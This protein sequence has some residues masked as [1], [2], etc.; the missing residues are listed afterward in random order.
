MTARRLWTTIN[1]MSEEELRLQ[2]VIPVLRASPDVQS[3]TDVHGQ[4]ER[5]LDVI[6]FTETDIERICYGLQLKKGAISGG[7]TGGKTV[8]QIVDQLQLADDYSHPIATKN[9]G[10]V[11][12]DRF[13]VATSGRISGTA[14]TEIASR[15]KKIPVQF[16]D[17]NELIRRIHKYLPQL[18]QVS[19]AASVSYLRTIQHR[20]DVLDALDQ[21]PGVAKRTLTQVFEEPRL[22]RIFDPTIA[23]TEAGQA[24]SGTLKALSLLSVEH[25]S[26]LIAD[27]DAGKTS[28]LRM[29]ALQ[30]VRGILSGALTG[31]PLPV[32]IRARDILSK[33]LSVP[34]AIASEFRRLGERELAE[35][36]NEDLSIGNYYVAVDSFSELSA[37]EDKTR[38]ALMIEE[39]SRE[40]PL[41]RVI[42]AGRPA[43]F[44]TPRYF[45]DFFHY[46]IDDFD[47]NQ[48][49]SLVRRWIGDSPKWAD[50]AHKMVDRLRE[51]LQLP[52]SPIPATIGVMLHEEQGRYITNTAEAIDRYMV[53]RLGRY[54]HELGMKQEVDW[55]RKQ[56]LLSEVAY[57]MVE[58]GSELIAEAEF[59]AQIEDIQRRQ[60]DTPRGQ[61][62]LEELVGSG[63]LSREAGGLSFFRTSFRDFF[64]AH[65]V[66]QRGDL[67][68]F[69]VEN[70]FER[71]WAST[72]VFAA[73]LRRS[74][75]R[76]LNSISAAVERHRANSVGGRPSDDY[77]FAAWVCGRV[78]ANSESADHGPKVAALRTTLAAASASVPELT[79]QATEQYGN[80]GHLMAIV[81]AEHSFF[82]AVGVPWIRNQLLEILNDSAIADE[83][84]YFLASVYTNLGYDDCYSVLTRAISEATSTKVLVVLQLLLWQLDETRR[85]EGPE[86]VALNQLKRSV[87]RRLAKRTQEVKSL[88]QLKSPALRLEVER[89]RR[90]Q[91]E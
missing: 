47:T 23:A 38:V 45:L 13:I 28:I 89:M 35:T 41:V 32:L 54:A 24:P 20:F 81:A 62:V 65:H 5:G 7:G 83:E 74:N 11:Q 30:Q 26:L 36:T 2:V 12:I 70:L 10:L 87:E 69:A 42:V 51:A 66:H 77:F 31:A 67:D 21:I 34:E 63:V 59:V 6:F 79:E 48:S 75:S 52:G 22:R 37:D 90:L 58:H 76:L 72:S 17:G 40:F 73:G 71:R 64:A 25:N 4:N 18:F 50:V 14:Q 43:D 55:A 86:R 84:R 9:A 78:L 19:D 82:V 80:I 56:D 46:H 49:A 15:L 1:D 33:G 53:I 39:F 60:G 44:L 61:Q 68:R 16:W 85:V 8:K 3:V 27:Q 88:L 91:R 57:Q 29:L